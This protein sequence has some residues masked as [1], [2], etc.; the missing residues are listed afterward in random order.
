MTD[1]QLLAEVKKG[2]SVGSSNDDMLLI[3]VTAVKEYML[4]YGIT[5]ENIETQLGIATLTVGVSDLWNI[6]AGEIKFS[7]AFNMMLTQLQ[8]KSLPDPVVN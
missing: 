1:Q 5:Q 3:K 4:N 6:T 8:A 2:L 7:P